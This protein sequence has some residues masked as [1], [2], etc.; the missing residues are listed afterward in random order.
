MDT[1]YASSAVKALP[2]A[3]VLSILINHPPFASMERKKRPRNDRRLAELSIILK[4]CF[5]KTIMLQNYARSVIEVTVTILSFDGGLLATCCNSITLALIDAGIS[6]YDYVTAVT[7]GIYDQTALLDLNSLE[8]ADLSFI[9]I[10][11][12]GDSDKLNL[13]LC[14]DR[15]PLDR[16]ERLISLGIEGCHRLKQLM[17]ETVREVGTDLLSKKQ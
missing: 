12:V 9:T 16:V 15:L 17:N 7:V 4:R 14:E 8:E 10:G 6:L 3:P 13:I 1:T 2:D 11:V 5:E